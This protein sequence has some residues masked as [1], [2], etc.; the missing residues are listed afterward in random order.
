[1]AFDKKRKSTGDGGRQVFSIRREFNLYH[2]FSNNFSILM[3]L[4]MSSINSVAARWGLSYVM[5]GLI[6][7]VG[8]ISYISASLILGRLGDHFGHKRILIIATFLFSFFNILGFF[9]VN[10]VELFIFAA[11]LNFFF[12]TF[13]PQ[14]EGLLSK[15]ERLLGVDP[16]S[17]INRFTISWSTGNIVGM[18]M[19]PFLIMRFPYL[20]FCYGIALNLAAYFILKSDFSKR[21]ESISFDPSPKL[22]KPSNSV[23]FPRIGLYRKVY[24]ITLVMTGLVYAAVL[25]LFPKV[26][27]MSGMPIALS[28][29]IVVGGNI[30][31]FL[32]FVFIGKVRIWVGKPKVASLFLLT[33]PLMILFIFI[34]SSP[35]TFF[36]IAFLAGVSYAVPYTY[37]IFYGLNSPDEDQGKQGGFHEAIMGMIWGIGPIVGGLTIQLSGGLVGLGLMAILLSVVIFLIQYRFVRLTNFSAN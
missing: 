30:G 20:V 10:A 7:L 11:G 4:L 32:T 22:K 17:T 18:A 21:G 1:M 6:N 31:V 12:G 26:I 28:G 3:Y 37:A 23:D 25:S 2:L 19:G 16:A 36:A 34:P 9:W 24:R 33:F 14:I 8:G 15:G 27:S 13:F 5:I 35:L 29:F